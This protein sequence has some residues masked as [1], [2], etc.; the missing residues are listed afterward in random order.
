MPAS[1][2]RHLPAQQLSSGGTQGLQVGVGLRRPPRTLTLQRE[3][4]GDVLGAQ[5][6]L[7]AAGE[8]PFVSH[9]H[10]RRPLQHLRGG[11]AAAEG[12]A[13]RAQLILAGVAVDDADQAQGLALRD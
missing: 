5:G 10:P 9:E 8:L 4:P 2:P 13:P 11:W 6:V 7:S 12:Q 3:P 1:P